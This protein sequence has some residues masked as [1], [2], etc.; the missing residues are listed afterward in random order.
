MRGNPVFPLPHPTLAVLPCDLW[1]APAA[2]QKKQLLIFWHKAGFTCDK[3]NSGAQA[4]L[5]FKETSAPKA[6]SR[7]FSLRCDGIC[8]AIPTIVSPAMLYTHSKR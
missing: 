4:L 2:A 1:V 8:C 5:F 6:P 7:L 3:S